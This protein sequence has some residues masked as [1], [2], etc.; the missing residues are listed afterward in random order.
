MMVTALQA[1]MQFHGALEQQEQTANKQDEVA[2]G[3]G[4]T[5]NRGWVSVT[6]QEML[7][8]SVRR[9]NI[10]NVRP[11]ARAR[12]RSASG[13]LSARMAMKIRLSMPS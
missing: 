3:E 8:S 12:S 13:S 5:E 10:A 9:M 2:P 1:L 6:S 7:A 11:T 4:L